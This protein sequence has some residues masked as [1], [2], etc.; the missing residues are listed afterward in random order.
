M[1]EIIQRIKE[2]YNLKTD[3]E[4]AKFLEIKPSTL[5]MQKNRGRLN[6]KRIL[7]KCSDL[8]RNWLLDGEGPQKKENRATYI[9]V[10]S[11]LSIA[12]TGEP[13]L[14]NSAK[15]GDIFVDITSNIRKFSPLD[16]VIG[17][18]ISGNGVPPPLRSDDIAIID[19]ERTTPKDEMMFLFSTDRSIF[20]RRVKKNS[21]D[22]YM[23]NGDNAEKAP[24]HI[25]KDQNN[26]EIIGE[27]I[28]IIRR[29]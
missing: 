20:C 29:V 2:A 4:V 17:Y 9:P 18:V 16:H 27:M 22:Y 6:L 8:N 13:N 10:Y 14:K 25:S 5:S 28:W 12:N 11:S 23:A 3:A 21:G 19:L 1:I 26:Y 24:V 7:E 15:I